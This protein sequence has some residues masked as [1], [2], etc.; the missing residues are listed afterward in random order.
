M[1]KIIFLSYFLL[2]F[3]LFPT[4]SQ[5]SLVTVEGSGEVVVKVLSLQDGLAL[6]PEKK[7]FNLVDVLGEGFGEDA[8]SLKKTDEK[9]ALFLG[10]K[11]REFDVTNYSEDL[12]EIEERGEVKS[13]RIGLSGGRFSIE[14]DGFLVLTDFPIKVDPR[15]GDVAVETSTGNVF[16]SVLPLEA[17][18]AALRARSISSVK[19]AAFVEKDGQLVYEMKGDKDIDIFKVVD[20]SVP[21]S[22]DVSVSTGEVVFVDQPVW[23]R[24]LTFLIG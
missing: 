11:N 15:E 7:E 19:E 22:V 8:I 20:Y 17:A 16:L 3:F 13:L 12:I 10:G 18:K 21:V 24:V 2:L 1:K 6:S 4:K 23:L 14:Q 5:A 9:V